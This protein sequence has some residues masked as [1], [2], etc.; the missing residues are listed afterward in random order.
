MNLLEG[1]EGAWWLTIPDGWNE[2]PDPDCATIVSAGELGALQLSSE[3]AAGDLTHEDLLELAREHLDAGAPRADVTAGDF[4][5]FEIAFDDGEA[6][7][8]QWYLRAGSQMLFAT[9]NCSLANIG[10]DDAA[11]EAALGSLGAVGAR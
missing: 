1:Q 10:V 11:V 4:R 3:I 6:Y 8:R 2:V 7:W 5:G 9:Y